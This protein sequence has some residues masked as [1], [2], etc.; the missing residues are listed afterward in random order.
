MHLAQELSLD[1]ITC[2]NIRNQLHILWYCCLAGIKPG[3][4][5]G[6]KCIPFLTVLD[7]S[8]MMLP[9]EELEKLFQKAGVDLKRP[10]CVSCGSGVTACHLILAAHLC[11][12]PGASV[13]DGSW[14]EWFIRAAPEHII[15]EAQSKL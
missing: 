3:H 6:S 9:P 15:S 10:M 1:V 7:A 4:I 5:P 11:G 12:Y 2:T 14:Y 8:G 13:Y